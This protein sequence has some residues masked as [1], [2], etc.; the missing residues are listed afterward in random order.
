MSSDIA[1]DQTAEAAQVGQETGPTAVRSRPRRIPARPESG[2]WDPISRPRA[3]AV[4]KVLLI[5]ALLCLAIGGVVWIAYERQVIARMGILE[6][7]DW[8]AL[9]IRDGGAG[10]WTV[11]GPG[12]P[13][14]EG[15]LLRAAEGTRALIHMPDGAQVRLD[16]AGEWQI[17]LLRQSRDERSSQAVIRQTHGQVTLASIAAEPWAAHRLYLQVPGS[18]I[19]M[20]GI[21]TIATSRAGATTVTVHQG[22]VH[23]HQTDQPITISPG[24]VAV[25]RANCEPEIRAAAGH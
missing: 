13:I 7:L 8:G 9:D 11:A 20:E 10:P 14:R 17:V 25:L 2:Q 15:A 4:L 21:A 12:R 6:S 3:R 18:T 23:I 5:V 19:E 16:S 24:Q 22:L 1:L